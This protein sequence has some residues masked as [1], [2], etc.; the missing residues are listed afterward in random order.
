MKGTTREQDLCHRAQLL[1]EIWQRL[2]EP[3]R[4]TTVQPNSARVEPTP[5]GVGIAL[6]APSCALLQVFKLPSG[7]PGLMEGRDDCRAAL[8][9]AD[10][11]LRRRRDC[12][13]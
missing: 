12:C 11:L 5:P 2:L 3:S 4:G 13:F 7:V 6:A 10:S 1:A 9:C 8:G